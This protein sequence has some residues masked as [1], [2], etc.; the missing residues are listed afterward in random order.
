MTRLVADKRFELPDPQFRSKGD[1]KLG[2]I[3]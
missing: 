3:H 1:F 2:A